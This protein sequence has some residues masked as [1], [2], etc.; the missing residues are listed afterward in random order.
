M[1][2]SAEIHPFFSFCKKIGTLLENDAAQCTCVL[3][4]YA[5]HEPEAYMLELVVIENIRIMHCI[6]S[7]K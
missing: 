2:Y 6:I 7:V 5:L 4:A 1:A 3:P